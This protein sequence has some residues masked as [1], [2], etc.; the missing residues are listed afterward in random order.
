MLIK[1]VSF[2]DD[3]YSKLR[4]KYSS[5]K[6]EFDRLNNE[7]TRTKTGHESLMT[8]IERGGAIA[9]SAT[10]LSEDIRLRVETSLLPVLFLLQA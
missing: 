4:E 3:E 7:Y 2:L 9:K 8:E 1:R 10:W 5:L 6:L